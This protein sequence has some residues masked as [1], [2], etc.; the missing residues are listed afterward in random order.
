MKLLLSTWIILS[1]LA[2]FWLE[3]T[4]TDEA[5][6]EPVPFAHLAIFDSSR[7]TL[8]AGTISDIDGAYR[9]ESAH[10]DAA[11]LRVSAVGYETR[12]MELSPNTADIR[13]T[14][15]TL[16]GEEVLVTA[17]S[18][19]ASA[20]ADRIRYYPD[21]QQLDL[22]ASAVDVLRYLPGVQVDLLNQVSLDG[23]RDVVI[24]V[25]GVVR[26]RQ[27]LQQIAPARIARIEIM[28]VPPVGLSATAT[29]AINVVLHAAQEYHLG[30][31]VLAEIPTAADEQFLFPSFALDYR[32]AS[33]GFYSAYSGEIT[34]FRIVDRQEI[35]I[36]GVEHTS[37]QEMRQRGSGHRFTTGLQY[38]PNDRHQTEVYGWVN[39]FVQ[40]RSGSSVAQDAAPI[41]YMEKDKNTSGYADILYRFNGELRQI[42]LGASVM[43]FRGEHE[44]RLG[45]GA[46]STRMSP[47]STT[48]ALKADVTEALHPTTQLQ[49]GAQLQ[50]ITINEL[51]DAEQ[52]LLAYTAMAYRRNR[53]EWNAGLQLAYHTDWNAALYPS[54]QMHHRFAPMHTA[55]RAS[56]RKS[57]TWPHMYQRSEA[58]MADGRFMLETGFAGIRP[59]EHHQLQLELT[60]NIG[61]H[62]LSLRTFHQRDVRSIQQITRIDDFNRPVTQWQNAEEGIN[63]TGLRLGGMFSAGGNAGV[64]FWSQ[65]AMVDVGRNAISGGASAWMVFQ[66][67]FTAS[68]IVSHEGEQHG[69]QRSHNSGTLYF[70]A[71]E[72]RFT[73]NASISIVSG[74]PFS[75]SFRYDGYKVRDEQMR[76][77]S[78][79]DITLSAV[80]LWFRLNVG[81][82]RGS[83]NIRLNLADRD[84][85]EVPRRNKKG[86]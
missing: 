26:D 60:R 51:P 56:Y 78:T 38:K 53:T 2:G 67:G 30:M 72:R 9:F 68:V 37:I 44:T 55:L 79:G 14:P 50:H 39:P 58:V 48:V 31:R 57:V 18:V 82:N 75:N 64:Q 71:V 13:L 69:M 33:W 5:T 76:I 62:V 1:S 83:G 47:A 70:V 34:N 63:T 73:Q 66:S 54:L 61:A 28:P 22:A 25:D 85:A 49:Y 7:T 81:F 4:V 16:T 24:L 42:Q 52:Q 29:G 35:A 74:L 59:A 27:Y 6:G 21:V 45:S 46:E 10:P 20:S 17:R 40:R 19:I 11:M 86:L 43:A 23:S 84:A 3:G 32:K 12:W 77:D 36:Q 8:V 41:A 80:P 65:F 15:V